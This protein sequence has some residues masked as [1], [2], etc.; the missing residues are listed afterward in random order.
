ML[1]HQL[2]QE[3]QAEV[4]RIA[5]GGTVVAAWNWPGGFSPGLAS[6]VRLDDGKRLFVKAMDA[7]AWPGEAATYRAE[8]AITAALPETVPAPRLH[9]S[10]D[11]G[12]WIVLVFEDIDGGEPSQPWSAEELRR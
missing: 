6:R 4:C 2:P 12:R 9:G 8:A 11:D 7:A 10:F 3:V 5:G 1:W